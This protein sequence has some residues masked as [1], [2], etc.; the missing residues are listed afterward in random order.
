MLNI[1]YLATPIIEIFFC[2]YFSS[3]IIAVSA[4]PIHSP[5]DTRYPLFQGSA[6]RAVQ[7][8]T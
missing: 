8:S 2:F 6:L 7:I 3:P 4:M 5:L 1:Q